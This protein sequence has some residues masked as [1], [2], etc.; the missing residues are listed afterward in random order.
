MEKKAPAPTMELYQPQSNVPPSLENY[1]LISFSLVLIA[2]STLATSYLDET[3]TFSHIQ[4][5]A[6]KDWHFLHNLSLMAPMHT[7]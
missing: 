4:S 6:F 1:L 2:L 7:H 3:Y 5:S